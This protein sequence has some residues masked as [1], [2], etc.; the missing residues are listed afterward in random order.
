MILQMLL[1]HMIGDFVLQTNYIAA[2]KGRSRVG[3]IFHGSIVLTVT[4]LI[5]LYYQA[6]YPAVPFLKWAFFIGITHILI[7]LSNLKFSHFIADQGHLALF[8]FV[9]DQILHLS[10]I[11]IALHFA[12]FTLSLEALMTSISTYPMLSGLLV[13][14]WM[15]M[16]AWVAI[17]FFVSGLLKREA[18]NFSQGS[19]HKYSGILQR[20]LITSALFAGF[21]FTVVIIPIVWQLVRH[22]DRVQ[23]ALKNLV[24]E[25]R[26][27]PDSTMMT[28]IMSDRGALFSRIQ[29]GPGAEVVVTGLLAISMSAVFNWLPLGKALPSLLHLF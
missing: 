5:T 20:W 13:Y 29:H 8:R 25:K 9:I 19:W 26:F 23:D 24:K 27:M 12:G 16:P 21:G 17:E 18:P 6:D 7:D 3:V 4:V 28:Q 14:V 15:S 2:W 10:V 22:R 1:A 11:A